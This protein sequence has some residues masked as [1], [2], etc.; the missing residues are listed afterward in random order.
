MYALDLFTVVFSVAVNYNVDQF[1][2]WLVCIVRNADWMPTQRTA[3]ATHANIGLRVTWSLLQS[4][5]IL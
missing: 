1:G 4:Q 5:A 2:L 3:A